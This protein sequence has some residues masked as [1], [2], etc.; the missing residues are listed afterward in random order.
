MLLFTNILN[1]FSVYFSVLYIPIIDKNIII[2]F[3]KHN[4]KFAFD[5]ICMK[6]VYFF[7]LNHN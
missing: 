4:I 1:C 2:A 6:S 3:D 5:I 7:R